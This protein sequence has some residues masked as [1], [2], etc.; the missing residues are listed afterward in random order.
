METGSEALFFS[1]VFFEKAQFIRVVAHFLKIQ[2]RA[3]EVGN[4]EPTLI[5][6]YND[7]IDP[8]AGVIF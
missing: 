6:V 3:L 8:G 4:L 5:F 1:C 7:A 2:E